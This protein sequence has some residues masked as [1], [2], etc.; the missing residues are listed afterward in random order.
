MLTDVRF[1]SL[2]CSDQAKALDFW[3]K[4]MGFDVQTD[5][6]YEEGSSERWIELK[7]PKGETYLV[8]ST[9]TEDNAR[10][11]GQFSPVWFHC[12]DLDKTHEE[13]SGKGVEFPVPPS[14][15]PWDPSTRW[16]QFKDPDGTMYGLSQ[17]S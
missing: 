7:L 15:A 5:A 2:F 11:L 14:E 6:P 17:R 12:D 16:A 3:T 8:L 10:L 9:A 1:T 13:L 4:T